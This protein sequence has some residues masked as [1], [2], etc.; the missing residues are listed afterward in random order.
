MGN[1]VGYEPM[2][3]E[4][5]L[6]ELKSMYFHVEEYGNG[7]YVAY[8]RLMFHWTI[9]KGDLDIP[10]GYEDRWCFG[11]KENVET[12]FAEWKS[13]NFTDEPIGWTRHPKTGRRRIAGDIASEYIAY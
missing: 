1:S 3:Q 9:I 5:H 11:D 2:T 12:C 4:D 8:Y 6:A 10:W 13:R 7:Q